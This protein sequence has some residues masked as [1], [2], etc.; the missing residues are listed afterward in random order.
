[1]SVLF[2]LRSFVENRIGR[3]FRKEV[4]LRKY[5]TV[6]SS[7]CHLQTPRSTN[8]SECFLHCFS[9]SF[10]TRRSVH[11]ICVI[12][13]HILQYRGTVQWK[14]CSPNW[15]YLNCTAIS[16]YLAGTV[17]HFLSFWPNCFFSMDE[18]ILISPLCQEWH[19]ISKLRWSCWT[20]EIFK[21]LEREIYWSTFSMAIRFLHSTWFLQL[22]IPYRIP[23]IFCCLYKRVE[24]ELKECWIELLRWATNV[25]YWISSIFADLWDCLFAR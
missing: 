1:M 10:L 8:F 3:R 4:N 2:P 9:Q 15:C 12:A 17:T 24:I 16:S 7:P 22:F 5:Q 23:L 14:R 11:L 18:T 13:V 25:E 19:F 21:P 6:R 20:L